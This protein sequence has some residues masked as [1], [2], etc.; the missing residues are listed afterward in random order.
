MSL[1]LF[2]I[3]HTK[4][5]NGNSLVLWPLPQ[6]N[7]LEKQSNP[8]DI[9]EDLLYDTIAGYIKKYSPIT[10]DKFGYS[11]PRYYVKYFVNFPYRVKTKDGFSWLTTEE[12]LKF[13]NDKNSDILFDL[14]R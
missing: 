1:E 8:L 3:C 5:V 12:L 14:E 11:N 2:I 9:A 7:L 4:D 10:L 13:R 6:A